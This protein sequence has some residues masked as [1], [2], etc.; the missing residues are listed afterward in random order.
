M[1]FNNLIGNDTIKNI[2]KT[3]VINNN[4]VHSYMFLGQEGIGKSIFAND[5]AEMLMC[6]SDKEKS[7]GKCKSCLEFESKNNPD[8]FQINPDGKSIKIDI[9]RNLQEKIIEK[10]IVSEKK[11]YIINNAD[12]MTIEAQNCLLKTLEEPPEY[13]TIILIVTNE[14]NILPTIKSRCMKIVFNKIEEKDFKNYILKDINMLN[15]SKDILNDNDIPVNQDGIKTKNKENALNI[16]DNILNNID[17][18]YIIKDSVLKMCDGSL[19]KWEK[20]KSKLQEYDIIDNAINN[21]EIK[22]KLEIMKDLEILYKS[23]DEIM[24]YLEFINVLLYNNFLKND[25]YKYI[26]SIKI[27]EKTRKNLLANSN[28]D[29]SIDNLLLKIWEEINEEYSWC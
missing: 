8:F 5:F 7:C 21:I 12:T 29:M 10:P 6:S 3:N 26:N 27:V 23:K 24:D 11:I 18:R 2:L 17:D 22:D 20:I 19:G 1:N 9:I 25:N 4:I 16:K 14:S 13:V 15:T 28:Y